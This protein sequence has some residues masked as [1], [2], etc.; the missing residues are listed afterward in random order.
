MDSA[1]GDDDEPAADGSRLFDV[2]DPRLGVDERLLH[3]VVELTVVAE[4]AVHDAGDVARVAKIELRERGLVVGA[5]TLEQR[6]FVGGDSQ[7][8]GSRRGH[9]YKVA[10]SP[11]IR[12]N[13]FS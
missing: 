5:K 1:N 4:K 9:G 12:L 8:C 2:G 3:D 10:F 6:R 11:R 7:H 13:F